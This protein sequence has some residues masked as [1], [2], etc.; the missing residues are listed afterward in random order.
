[1]AL[2]LFFCP[3]LSKRMS[4]MGGGGSFTLDKG[5]RLLGL[6]WRIALM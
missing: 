3:F 1:M 5:E 4:V 6:V 2:Y